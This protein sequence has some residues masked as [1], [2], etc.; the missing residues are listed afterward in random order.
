M[1]LSPDTTI[2]D[3]MEPGCA[4]QGGAS[5]AAALDDVMSAMTSSKSASS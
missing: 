5:G 2:D 1:P 4:R 3:A